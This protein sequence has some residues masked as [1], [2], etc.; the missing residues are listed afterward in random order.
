MWVDYRGPLSTDYNDREISC[1]MW[2]D[3]R[4]SFS[5]VY[6]KGEISTRG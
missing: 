4:R 3:Y 2:V 1:N 5:T 6:N